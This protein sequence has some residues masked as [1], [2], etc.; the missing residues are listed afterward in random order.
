MRQHGPN[1]LDQ[2]EK[3]RALGKSARR[4]G[5]EAASD[6]LRGMLEG[7]DASDVIPLVR[8]FTT[9]FYLA[10]VSEQVH[11]I[12]QIAPDDRYLP[13]S[14]D[15]IVAA[16]LDPDLIAEVLARFEVRPVLKAHPTEVARRSILTKRKALADLLGERLHTSDSNRQELIDARTAELI[17]QIWQTDELRTD[18]PSAVEE[19]RSIL[20]Y[21]VGLA[22]D[23]V[24][25]SDAARSRS[26]RR[27]RRETRRGRRATRR[28]RRANRRKRR[29]S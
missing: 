2:V 5:S 10:N 22:E 16:D 9:Y 18:R 6:E 28:R 15:R 20:Y 19:A 4:G 26:P 1:L 14:V 7:L 12:D 3:V 29:A 11:R 13:S 25:G 27:G 8:A 24:G 21:L 23:V 17:D